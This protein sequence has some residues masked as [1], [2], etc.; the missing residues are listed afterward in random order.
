MGFVF[1]N[2]VIYHKTGGYYIWRPKNTRW[3]RR[4]DPGVFVNYYQT[5]STGKLQQADINIF[6][7]WIIFKDNS[8]L[9]WDIFLN[10]QQIDF[11]FSPLSIPIAKG[12]YNYVRNSVAYA[13]DA[14]KKLSGSLAYEW[15]G[16]YNGSLKGL[17]TW[18]RFAPLPRISLRADYTRNAFRG[19]GVQEQDSNIDLYSGELRMAYNPR[20]QASLFYQ[21]NSLDQQG[22]W[23]ARGSWE[24]APLSFLYIVFNE[25]SFKNL[26]VKNQSVI[27]KISYL[28][29]F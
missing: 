22:R 17:N 3:I 7:V 6:P 8:K 18:V 14:S 1:G 24:F 23:N 29:Q 11:A 19:V 9:T 13:S 20:L 5:A 16:Y 28:K 2:D 27:N 25:T 12:A 4:W 21:Y 15:G 10:R 26:P